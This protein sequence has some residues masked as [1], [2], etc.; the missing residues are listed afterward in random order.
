MKQAL[1]FI[2]FIVISSFTFGQN[3]SYTEALQWDS[4]GL[5]KIE[6]FNGYRK[7]NGEFVDLEPLNTTELDF[8][9]PD[10]L[11]YTVRTN[12]KDDYFQNV[13]QYI[14][15]L[16]SKSQ[17]VSR[18]EKERKYYPNTW[19]GKP[20]SILNYGQTEYW[21]HWSYDSIQRISIEIRERFNTYSKEI[22]NF[23][24]TTFKY[25]NEQG[26]FVRMETA[27]NFQKEPGR[28]L[29]SLNIYDLSD[30]LV[31]LEHYNNEELYSSTSYE[32][33][34]FGPIVRIDSLHFD[35]YSDS[36]KEHFSQLKFYDNQLEEACSGVFSQYL[37][38]YFELDFISDSVG[39]YFT[40]YLD[41]FENGK[42]NKVTS[43]GNQCYDDNIMDTIVFQMDYS[44]SLNH[45]GLVSY[46]YQGKFYCDEMY[47]DAYGNR[48]MGIESNRSA[49]RKK[50][51]ELVEFE[52]LSSSKQRNNRRKEKGKRRVRAFEYGFKE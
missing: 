45:F 40:Q 36:Y 51:L 7:K 34:A 30:N 12:W 31:R 41:Y 35:Y 18:G 29:R 11:R 33:G 46:M 38:R 50:R 16:D 49:Q 9:G 37:W 26:N 28:K 42:L 47:F 48:T 10:S 1:S 15:K 52:Y 25:F 2:I 4:I 19:K 13:K 8:V 3:L 20:D 43:V 44:D 27:S 24:D 23:S 32:F 21:T 39:P 6:E 5:Q 22:L 14:I 17:I